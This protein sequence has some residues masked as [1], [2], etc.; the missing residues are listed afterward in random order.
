MGQWA[1]AS[2]H[3]TILRFVRGSEFNFLHRLNLDNRLKKKCVGLTG[4][5]NILAMTAEARS[6]Q[7]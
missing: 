3:I 4:K 2:G 1:F 5:K 7:Q 6:D